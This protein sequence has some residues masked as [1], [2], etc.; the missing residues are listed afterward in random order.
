MIYSKKL[1][2]QQML[3]IDRTLAKYRKNQKGGV[4][5]VNK[6]VFWQVAHCIGIKFLRGNWQTQQVV[7]RKA[8][9]ISDGRHHISCRKRIFFASHWLEPY[10]CA[11]SANEYIGNKK[12]LQYWVHSMTSSRLITGHFYR[13]E[14][15]NYYRMSK[16][17]F[18]L[19][20]YKYHTEGY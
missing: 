18:E 9:A 13:E 4:T 15:F 12:N 6:L 3:S 5:V 8:N 17:S 2:D 7:G 19:L 11:T 20:L 16:S 10:Y 1:T 14:L